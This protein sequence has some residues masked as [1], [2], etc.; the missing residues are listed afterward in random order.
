VNST[1]SGTP[2][3]RETG[4]PFLARLLA[5]GCFVGYV[6]WASGTFGSLL[7]ILIYLIPGAQAVPILGSMIVVGFI[8][9][10]AAAGMVAKAEGDK[11]S[12]TAALT[13]SLFQ[14]G[15][16]HASDPS[17]VVIDEIVGMWI[18]LLWLPKT[19][20]A[21]T[22]AF[23]AF[24]CFDIVKPEPARAMERL[25]HGF[26]IMLDDVVAAV[27]ANLSTQVVLYVLTQ[28]LHVF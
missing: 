15:S 12:K 25:P 6:P 20:V 19:F 9:G 24:R 26:G 18:A 3:N 21:I 5:T 27:Y 17:I 4:V 10:T 11:L 13:K 2:N 8:L 14:D 16:A 28:I 7:G 1:P 22:L 23:L